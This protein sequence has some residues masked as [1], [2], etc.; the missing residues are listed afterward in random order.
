MCVI[1]L[2]LQSNVTH[3]PGLVSHE[4]G[5]HL[6]FAVTHAEWNKL[7]SEVHLPLTGGNHRIL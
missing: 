4:P 7:P 6:D 3:T 5:G 2:S 1:L